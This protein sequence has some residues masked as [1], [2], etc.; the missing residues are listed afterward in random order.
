MSNSGNNSWKNYGGTYKNDNLQNIS[1]GTLVADNVLLRQTDSQVLKVE[2]SL[3]VKGDATISGS[4][5]TVENNLLTSYLYTSKDAYINSKLY[6]GTNKQVTDAE[7]HAFIT[8]TSRNIGINTSNL[9][10]GPYSSLDVVGLPNVNTV[11][12]VRSR[13]DIN[14]NIISENKNSHGLIA[15]TEDKYTTDH[16]R[17]LSSS[18]GVQFVN[19]SKIINI[20][21]KP[22]QPVD[23]EIN[24]V[25]N[26]TTEKGCL[27]INSLN[28]RF[29]ASNTIFSPRGNL[30][31]K[32]SFFNESV[33]IYDASAQ[34]YLVGVYN[35]VSVTS[36]NSLSLVSTDQSA[37]N[38]LRLITPEL[39]G[40]SIGGGSYPLDITRSMGTIGINMNIKDS[41]NNPQ[42]HPTQV[43][44][45][46]NSVVNYK[47]T[48]GVNT[49]APETEKYIMDINGP[50][51]IGNG[52]LSVVA[53]YNF[54]VTS[55]S[56]SKSNKN[57]G[58]V[59]GKPV[60]NPAPG[61]DSNPFWL[62]SSFTKNGGRTWSIP[63]RIDSTLNIALEAG[64]SGVVTDMNTFVLD[65][66]YAV[67]GCKTNT[68]SALYYTNNSGNKWIKLTYPDIYKKNQ[69]SFNTICISN[70]NK[71]SNT[72]FL[73]GI[74]GE[75][76]STGQIFAS[77]H[78][79]NINGVNSEFN[80][81]TISFNDDP[82]PGFSLTKVNSC[83]ICG[84]ILY[85]AGAGIQKYNISTAAP[86]S[87]YSIYNNGF[88]IKTYNSIFAYDCSYV[89]AVGTNIISYTSDGTNWKDSISNVSTYALNSVYLY[90]SSNG[91]AVDNSGIILYTTDGSVTWNLVP[92]NILNS[93]GISAILTGSKNKLT[94]ITIQDID[95]FIITNTTKSYT[96][97]DSGKSKIIYGFF[98][99]L[100]NHINNKVFDVSGNMFISGDV[101]INEGG[102]IVSTNKTFKLLNENVNTIEFGSE[103]TRFNIGNENTNT[104]I[105]GNLFVSIDTSLNSNLYVNKNTSLNGDISANSRLFLGGDASLNRR[106]FV[107][108]DISANNRLFLGGDAKLN[109]RLFVE[110]DST[111]NG[112][113]IGRGSGYNVTN[114]AL[115]NNALFNNTTGAN[116]LAVGYQSLQYNTG[117]NYNVAI[118]GFSGNA[119]T[120]GIYNT[121][122]GSN[123]NT[124]GTYNYSTAIGYNATIYGSNQ[125]VLG[126]SNETVIIKGD[127][128]FNNRLFVQNDVSMNGNLSVFN[129]IYS[130][131]ID[132]ISS[133]SLNI[134]CS[135]NSSNIFIGYNNN[136][137]SITI[138]SKTE[139]TS[140]TIYIGNA[141]DNVKIRGN[142]DV[143]NT[144][145]LVVDSNTIILND[146][147]EQPSAGSGFFIYDN[148]NIINTDPTKAG[149]FIVSND[150]LGFDVKA[151]GS[152]NIVK[153]N[154]DSMKYTTGTYSSSNTTT[155]NAIMVLSPIT[156]DDDNATTQMTISDLDTASIFLNSNST[157]MT[158][159]RVSTKVILGSSA[160]LP[161]PT[162]TAVNLNR[163]YV[164]GDTVIEGSLT[165]KEQFFSEMKLNF[166]TDVSINEYLYVGRDASLNS[167]L[168]VSD[169][170]SA[171]S[172]LFLGG[173][174]LLNSRLYVEEDIS[175][176]SSFFLGGD[177]S[178]NSRLYV[179]EDISANSRLFLG[180]DASINGNVWIGG[181]GGIRI[182]NLVI[183][184]GV[185][186]QF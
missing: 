180:G 138:G 140:K 35:D 40:L 136:T 175:A 48:I 166:T 150:I 110:L 120:T 131:N 27:D 177:A 151:P 14:R 13:T 93:S 32:T 156:N 172:R 105:N 165:V 18:S 57:Y 160:L 152:S 147:T 1:I 88:G 44:V 159:Q 155:G 71:G 34:P 114:T 74:S 174:A 62:Y 5:L 69:R 91:L 68:I 146:K 56:F 37:N 137:S 113:T 122:I 96:G 123:T 8:G 72:L 30:N 185:I 29:D 103:A 171:N 115:G 100:F 130:P 77:Y 148:T 144:T 95:S 9:T 84:N 107:S 162:L 85:Y 168:Y 89:V 167:R 23:A 45:G 101:N 161:D 132:N 145:Q 7:Q 154:T 80:G 70:A 76:I 108:N 184:D 182:G 55:M 15:Y 22:I 73:T 116:N 183:N 36:G 54:E 127:S 106:L 31:D 133:T 4:S 153:I 75:V 43:I 117:G 42:Y 11:L 49:Y 119:N 87:I 134:G 163:L 28:V 39:T 170:I 64:I 19:N 81:S 128:S 109:G 86:S 178:L 94:N 52:E 53:D 59:S 169:N 179:E 17:Q 176:N 58:I 135:P 16:S 10:G 118:G 66:S 67:I 99:N 112:I 38:F 50:V 104:H 126:T 142:V 90:D 41:Y 92:D 111:I 12:T 63:T 51:R 26:N 129:T 173:D 46:G 97:T 82:M 78:K 20:Q 60:N 141:G 124:S 25:W 157:S 139:N 47:S 121:F 164:V 143:V 125:M 3:I 6:F 158:T 33:I 149:Q 65:N 21:D 24:F 2:G 79:F 102:K 181:T 98:P 61:P 83:D 186:Y